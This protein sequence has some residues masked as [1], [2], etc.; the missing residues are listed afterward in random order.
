MEINFSERIEL[1]KTYMSYYVDMLE[2]KNSIY[3]VVITDGELEK[4]GG[5]FTPMPPKKFASIHHM[6]FSMLRW[7]QHP[8]KGWGTKPDDKMH[9]VGKDIEAWSLWKDY[10]IL[11]FEQWRLT[12]NLN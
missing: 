11:T 5:L 10:K 4:W 9:M 8:M 6:D 3:Y 7:F 12:K 1:A 2:L